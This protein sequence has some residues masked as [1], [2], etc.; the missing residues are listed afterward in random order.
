M[1]ISLI[2][3]GMCETIHCSQNDTSARK[4]E[5]EFYHNGKKFQVPAGANVFFVTEDGET[6]MYLDNEKWIVE[7]NSEMTGK[8]GVRDCK[9]KIVDGN[10]ILYTQTIK[11]HC[12]ERP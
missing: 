2:P 12:E 7:C 8:V 10:E 1:V 6:E 5:F 4:F 3:N 9:I 11:L